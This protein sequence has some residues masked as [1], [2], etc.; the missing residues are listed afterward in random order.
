MPTKTPNGRFNLVANTKGQLVFTD[1]HGKKWIY[2]PN[3]Y[4]VHAKYY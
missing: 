1:S 3:R 4:Y 2:N